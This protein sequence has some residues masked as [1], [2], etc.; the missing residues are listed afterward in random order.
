MVASLTYNTLDIDTTEKEFIN[1]LIYKISSCQFLYKL[2]FESSKR[3]G[4]HFRLWCAKKCDLCRL[5][6][7][8]QIRYQYDLMRNFESRN[9]LAQ[10]SEFHLIKIVNDEDLK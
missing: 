4:F 9:V 3:K 10:E 8:D 1:R 5:V 7:D 6:F 2:T